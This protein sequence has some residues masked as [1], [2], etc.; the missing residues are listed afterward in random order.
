MCSKYLRK[1]IQLLVK[2]KRH[3]GQYRGKMI[4]FW[5]KQTIAM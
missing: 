4:F 5:L 2:E 1:E 3:I